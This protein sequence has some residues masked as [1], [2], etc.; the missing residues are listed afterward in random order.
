LKCKN[1]VSSF[2]KQAIKLKS[3]KPTNIKKLTAF[4]LVTAGIFSYF[5]VNAQIVYTNIKDVTLTCNKKCAHCYHYSLGKTYPLDL[6]NDGLLDFNITAYREVTHYDGCSCDYCHCLDDIMNRVSITAL[7]DNSVIIGPSGTALISGSN[8]SS[9]SEWSIGVLGNFSLK[10]AS[11]GCYDITGQCV[12]RTEGDWPNSS[13]RYLGL[14]I[15]SNGQ[16]YYGWARLSVFVDKSEASFKIKDYAYESTPGKSIHAGDIGGT[17]LAISSKNAALVNLKIFPNPVTST[18]TI[19]FSLST[20]G[21]VSIRLYDKTGIPVMNVT[22]QEFAKGIQ[23]I[24]LNTQDLNA[25]IYLL[26]LESQGILQT[27]KFI[28]MK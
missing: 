13:D 10:S 19:T 20:Q 18:A 21:R 15:I 4:F 24:K 22:D 8:I 1:E 7:N 17:P 27:R 11:V 25:G 6:N 12:I 14:R 28:V 2:L 16:T 9:L 3:M 5:A 26:R 23:Q